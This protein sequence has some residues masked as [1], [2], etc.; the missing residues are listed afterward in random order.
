MLWF[1]PIAKANVSCAHAH[2][3]GQKIKHLHWIEYNGS[4][5]NLFDVFSHSKSTNDSIGFDSIIYLTWNNSIF[6]SWTIN[7]RADTAAADWLN[8]SRKRANAV[9]CM[10]I[11]LNKYNWIGLAN[12]LPNCI[13]IDWVEQ[14]IRNFI[15]IKLNISKR[16]WGFY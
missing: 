11:K 12:I 4:E 2:F 14:W 9:H 3:H 5:C 15:P 6:N 13:A 7:Q 8:W 1:E 10:H 16:N